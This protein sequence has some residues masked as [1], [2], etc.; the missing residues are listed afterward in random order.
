M[1]HEKTRPWGGPS[2][3]GSVN[4]GVHSMTNA[5]MA[6]SVAALTTSGFA[7]KEKGEKDKVGAAVRLVD[8]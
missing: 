2:P 6:D 3:D 7:G 1:K 8:S 4:A 5:Y